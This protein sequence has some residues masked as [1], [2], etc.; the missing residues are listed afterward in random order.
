MLS[1]Q[2]ILNIFK[3]TKAIQILYFLLAASIIQIIDLF[4]TINFTNIFGVYLIM[5]VICCISLTG[6]FFSISR[7]NIL[8]KII[9]DNCKNGIFPESYFFEITGIF[10]TA[11]LIF[12]P[13]FISTVLGF[14]LL[15]PI[16]SEQCGKVISSKISTDWHTVYE[17]MKI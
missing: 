13:G 15:L 14:L 8:I 1:I 11:L 16:L 9:N 12:M 7:I 2:F 3:E 10:L 4:V 17:Y 5:A 6:L